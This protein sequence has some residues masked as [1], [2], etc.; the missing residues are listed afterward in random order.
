MIKLGF[1][2]FE[3][4]LGQGLEDVRLL[5][6]DQLVL[7]QEEDRTGTWLTL[8]NGDLPRNGPLVLLSRFKSYILHVL[9]SGS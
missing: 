9:V 2:N 8:T 6:L 7:L 1:L 5:W 3:L 4:F